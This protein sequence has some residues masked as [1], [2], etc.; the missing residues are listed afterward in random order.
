MSRREGMVGRFAELQLVH[1]LIIQ[2][3]S[4]FTPSRVTDVALLPSV[5]FPVD[6]TEV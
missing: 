2:I 1:G 4:L 3:N 5:P 6:F